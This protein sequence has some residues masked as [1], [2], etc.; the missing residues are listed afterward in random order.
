MTALGWFVVGWLGIDA[1][2]VLFLWIASHLNPP[3][4]HPWEE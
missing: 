1:A 2:I 4:D 3:K